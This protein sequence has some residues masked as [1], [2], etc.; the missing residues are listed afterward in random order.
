MSI[1]YVLVPVALG[2]VLVAVGAYVWSVRSGQFDDLDTPALRPLID[3]PAPKAPER[4][5]V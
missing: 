3:E 4:R 1:L 5:K 2:L